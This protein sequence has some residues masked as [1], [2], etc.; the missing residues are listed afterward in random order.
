MQLRADAQLPPLVSVANALRTVTEHLAQE[1][2]GLRS[3]A[4]E[5]SGVDWRI[6]R[7]VASM[8]GVS[9]VLAEKLRWQGPED[10][11]AF[12]HQQR[13]HIAR[14]Q[15]RLWELL[16]RL[17]ERCRLENVP[18]QVLKG[19]ALHLAGIYAHGQRPM[20]D[21]DLLA[22]PRHA[23]KAAKI[24]AT[25]GFAAGR[26]TVKHQTF[27]PQEAKG[28]CSFG[29]YSD[30]PLK[31]EL[32]Q[33]ICEPLPHRLTDI[34]HLIL[35]ADAPPGL[36]TYP[37]RSALMAHLLLH[38]AGGMAYRTVRMIQLHD[39][40]LL[41]RCLTEGEWE[42]LIEWR[43]WWAWPPLMLC[44]RYYRAAVPEKVLAAARACCPRLLRLCCARQ[45]LSDVSLSR[46]GLEAVPGIEW[47]RSPAEA[48]AFAARRIV[49]R[50]EVLADRKYASATD[51]SLAQ[52]DWAALSQSRR[53]LRALR[54]RTPRPWPLHNVRAALAE[55]H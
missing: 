9:G 2:S 45:C 55:P 24:L 38:T 53:I 43:P 47:A 19:T 7:A 21:L 32:H 26:R 3:T 17:G 36:N 37:S 20:A 10:W 4:P 50:S 30:N 29:E 48:L 35:S 22:A 52:S 28:A 5:W 41:A 6:A 42:Q 8:H 27:E 54:A 46:L 25:L 16:D 23:L 12:L 39:I 1:L 33:R 51:P 11:C 49:P 14:R 40:A 13:E 34:S 31:I 15:L 18:V 44:G